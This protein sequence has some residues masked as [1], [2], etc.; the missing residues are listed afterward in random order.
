MSNKVK[1]SDARKEAGL[2]EMRRQHYIEVAAYYIAE[3]NSGHD[4]D[5]D[6]WLLAEAK[7]DQLLATRARSEIEHGQ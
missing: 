4:C 2:G 3:K 1:D 7:V 5:V 6:N